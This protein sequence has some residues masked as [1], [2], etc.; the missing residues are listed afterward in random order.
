MVL[1]QFQHPLGQDPLEQ[2]L[3]VPATHDQHSG[4]VDVDHGQHYG[5]HGLMDFFQPLA[6]DPR[7]K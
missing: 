7:I 5:G 4:K 2:V 1:R 3:P 6:A